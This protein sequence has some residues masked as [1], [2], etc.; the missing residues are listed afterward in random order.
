VAQSL[1]Q[2]V[3]D[4]GTPYIVMELLSGE[5]LGTRLARDGRLELDEASMVLAQLAKALEAAHRL[6]IVHR[7]IKPENVFLSKSGDDSMIVKVIDF[8]IAKAVELPAVSRLTGGGMMLGTPEY[9]SPEQVMNSR[10]VD[11]RADLWAMAVVAYEMLT[12]A[13]PFTGK[14]IGELCCTLLRGEFQPPTAIV[15]SLPPN[16]DTWFTRAL[17]SEPGARFSSARDMAAA[18]VDRDGLDTIEA[19]SPALPKT[20]SPAPANV[21]PSGSRRKITVLAILG[22]ALVVLALAAWRATAQ[23]EPTPATNKV[24]AAP[25][26]VAAHKEE[27]S[28]APK[29]RSDHPSDVTEPPTE[30]SAQ[31]RSTGRSWHDRARVAPKPK[32]RAEEDPGF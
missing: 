29:P 12:G 25:A 1:D 18:F 7:D 23:D 13:R 5:T 3:T 26:P 9:M 30:S 32:P 17:H 19:P 21:T 22:A 8:G 4:D 2:G 16:I 14:D 24:Q 20:S 31:S 15:P 6:G 27:P 10:D 28:D 11:Y